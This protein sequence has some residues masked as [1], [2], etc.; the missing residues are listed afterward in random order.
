MSIRMSY[1]ING[2]RELDSSLREAMKGLES[3]EQPLKESGVYMYQSIGK[4]F[5]AQGRPSKWKGHHWLTKKIRGSGQILADSGRLKQSVTSRGAGSKYELSDRKLVI[6]SNVKAN[7]SN[8]LL[9]DIMQNGLP[10]GVNK[11]FGNPGKNGIPARPFLMIHDE[12]AEMIER[13]FKD[14]VEGLFR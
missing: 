7:N 12:D 4:N 2:H 10:A 14:Y 6:G 1:K 5:D 13:I 9:A 11:V 3:F 8:R